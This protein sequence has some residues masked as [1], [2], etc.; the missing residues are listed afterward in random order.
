MHREDASWAD[1][2]EPFAMHSQEDRPN[3]RDG[4]VPSDT[5]HLEEALLTL[6]NSSGDEDDDLL[7]HSSDQEMLPDDSLEASGSVAIPTATG[8]DAT[9][10]LAIL[11]IA[12]TNLIESLTSSLADDVSAELRKNAG[13]ILH[14]TQG[15]AQD[16]GR[17]M[18]WSVASLRHLWLA[19]SALPEADKVPLLDAPVSLDGSIGVLAGSESKPARTLRRP[20]TD[21]HQVAGSNSTP[22]PL[23]SRASADSEARGVRETN[24]PLHLNSA[25]SQEIETLLAKSAIRLV[26][27]HDEIHVLIRSDNKATVAYVNRQGGT[28]CPHLHRLA[29][30]IWTWAYPRVRSLRAL[31]VPG[32]LN[33]GAD[34][35]SRGGPSPLEWCLHPLVVAEA[36]TVDGR[37]SPA[38]DRRPVA[39]SPAPGPPVSGGGDH[40]SSPPKQA[41]PHGLAPVRSR[42]VNM[43]LSKAAVNTIQHARAISTTMAYKGRWEAFETWCLERSQDPLVCPVSVV[44]NF[45]QSLLD[46]GLSLSTIR[47]Y[48]FAISACHTGYSGSTVA[49]H[50]LVKRFIQG[51]RRLKPVAP[52]RVPQWDLTV[53]LKALCSPPFE[54]LES[55]EWRALSLKVALLT[56]LVSAKRVSDLCALSVHPDCLSFSGSDRVVLRPNPAFT[57]KVITTSFRSRV[58]D[59]VAFKPP[60][61]DDEEDAMLH[62]LCPVRA[63]SIYVRRSQPIRQAD[64]LFV[65][66]GAA[67]KGKPV[68]AQRFSHWLTDA[69]NWA[70]ECMGLP[71]LSEV[72]A[73]S[74]RSMAASRALFKG[75]SVQDICTAASWSSPCAFV[76]FYLLDA[77]TPSVAHAVLSSASNRT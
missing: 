57:P 1:F 74:T 15:L 44:L 23:K 27:K 41:A 32:Q 14:L 39:T 72:R 18:G 66:Y 75:V 48:V 68:T 36:Q 67:A 43:G 62:K 19:N 11:A 28:K 53:V 37:C 40:F 61:H 52:P 6:A 63:L 54:P 73:H 7:L 76:R 69:I 50:P 77:S 33:C 58:L 49:A 65:C 22:P 2:P 9:N 8:A 13:A 17:I 71:P 30:R 24:M 38:A 56:A 45:V 20:I 51:V 70:Y 29:V 26:P 46:K 16:F 55:V 25:L 60:P 4:R 35:L 64:Q 42:L 34:L 10:N 47:G 59:L 31:Y 5:A 3:L 21:K 12:Q